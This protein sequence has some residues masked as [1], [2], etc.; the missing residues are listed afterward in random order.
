MAGSFALFGFFPP[1]FRSKSAQRTSQRM[2]AFLFNQVQLFSY[3]RFVSL[4]YRSRK[5]K[6][7]PLSCGEVPGERSFFQKNTPKI[8]CIFQKLFIF[9]SLLIIYN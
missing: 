4:F 5:K 8:S 2:R 3:S 9:V 1:A 7:H 6:Q